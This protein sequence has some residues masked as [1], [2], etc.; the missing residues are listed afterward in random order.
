[1]MEEPLL[2]GVR[3]VVGHI[4]SDERLLLVEI[5]RLLESSISGLV[6]SHTVSV[7]K[8]DVLGVSSFVVG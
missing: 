7:D 4:S 3:S 6:A 2:G 5:S 8:S 1:M